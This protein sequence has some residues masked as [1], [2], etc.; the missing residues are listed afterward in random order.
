MRFRGFLILVVLLFFPL[1][2]QA[3]SIL[4][5][6]FIKLDGQLAPALKVRDMDG[7]TFD[8]QEHRGH[9]IFV[10]FWASWCGPCR[11]ELPAI[12]TLIESSKGTDLQFV[13]VNTAEDEDTIFEFIGRFSPNLHTYMDPDGLITEIWQPRGLPTTFFIDPEG[14]MQYL[15]L[16]G[17][18]WQSEAHQTFLNKLLRRQ[19]D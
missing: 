9:W 11:K 3:E 7:Q 12:E 18:A 1:S 2:S 17:Q 13:L 6:G 15:A 16:G 5:K 14:R 10:H 19:T 4:P 8:I